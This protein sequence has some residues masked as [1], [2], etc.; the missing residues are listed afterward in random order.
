MY[1]YPNGYK[2]LEKVL[3]AYSLFFFSFYIGS[4]V[5]GDPTL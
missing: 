3:F 1:G 4:L 2:K 5:I